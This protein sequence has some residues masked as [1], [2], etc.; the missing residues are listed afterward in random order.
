MQRSSRVQ[1]GRKGNN[2]PIWGS[3]VDVIGLRP[4]NAVESGILY[5]GDAIL[6]V[7]FAPEN[8]NKPVGIRKNLSFAGGAYPACGEQLRIC[9]SCVSV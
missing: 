7:G 9:P 2:I 3:D 6:G 1:R 5:G 4:V 8:V